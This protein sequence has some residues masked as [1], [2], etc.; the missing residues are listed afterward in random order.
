MHETSAELLSASGRMIGGYRV[1]EEVGRGAMGVVYLAEDLRLRR[2]VAVKALPPHL[3]RDAHSRERLRHEVR[4]AAALIHSNIATVLTLEE[5]GDE[6]F[7]ISEYVNGQTLR[8]VLDSGSIPPP[9][10]LQIAIGVAHGLA[11][12][13]RAGIV[14]RHLK[15]ENIMRCADGGVKV[16]D[17]GLLPFDEPSTGESATSI[18]RS[19]LAPAPTAYS[20]PEQ[21]AGE[22]VDFRTDLFSF[23]VVLYELATGRPPFQAGTA[24]A[25]PAGATPPDY[26]PLQ[27]P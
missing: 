4:A 20:S 5:H 25:R 11:A 21:V 27:A 3:T 16:L 13:H 22:I 17:F 19:D 6:V 7:V 1:L 15:P 8:Q 24:P 18:T 2:S 26:V 23:G 9:K 14:H 10:V 12:A